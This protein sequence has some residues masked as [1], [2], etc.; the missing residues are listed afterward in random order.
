LDVV[1]FVAVVLVV[2][3]HYWPMLSLKTSEVNR[4]LVRSLIKYL[5]SLPVSVVSSIYFEKLWCYIS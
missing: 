1:V 4:V 5:P 2:D 3:V